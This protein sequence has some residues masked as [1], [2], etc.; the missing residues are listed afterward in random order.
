M[1][2]NG[3]L[4]AIS[5]P[6]RKIGLLHQKYRDHFGV[7]GDDVLVV[8]GPST[9]FNPQLSQVQIDAAIADDPEG[10]RAEWEAT[11]RSDLSA[12]LDDATIDAAIDH[13]RPLELVR[14]HDGQRRYRAFVDPSG[15][16]HDAFTICIGHR[17]GYG[18]GTRFVADVV[19]ARRPPF[20][21]QQVVG[22]YCALLKQFGLSSVVGDRYSAEW[23]A[24]SFGTN[25]IRYEP[26][27]KSKSD[28]YLEALPFFT[29]GLISIPNLT[30]LIRELRLLDRQTHRGGRD[31]VDHPRRGFDDLANAL[32]GCASLTALAAND[33]DTSL[34]W[35]DPEPA[36]DMRLLEEL[37]RRRYV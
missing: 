6:Y 21:P 4:I 30:P 8:Q 37:M 31:T 26:S 25:N 15:G 9:A 11:F 7:D 14:R 2:T 27:E 34:S 13:N 36:E 24:S 1:T 18:G 3:M 5:T 33:F 16:R 29:R 35:I 10:A 12:F 17:E 20:D 32:C 28:L 23:V 19:R 22:E